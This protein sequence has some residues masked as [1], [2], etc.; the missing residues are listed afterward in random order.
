[1]FIEFQ[2]EGDDS[3]KIEEHLSKTLPENKRSQGLTQYLAARSTGTIAI[4][5][6]VGKMGMIS[7][8]QKES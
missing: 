5:K 1:M 3:L 4:P 6:P 2:Q 7:E 8:I